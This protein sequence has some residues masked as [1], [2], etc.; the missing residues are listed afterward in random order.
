M[1]ERRKERSEV[2]KRRHE[3]SRRERENRKGTEKCRERER[4]DIKI[5]KGEAIDSQLG[6]VS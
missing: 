3:W 6:C 1:E 2:R 5:N 4:E